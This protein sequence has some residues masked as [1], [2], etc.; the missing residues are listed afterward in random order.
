MT[1]RQPGASSTQT[2][3]SCSAQLPGPPRAAWSCLRRCLLKPGRRARADHPV[4]EFARHRVDRAGGSQCREILDCGTQ[5]PQRE[6]GSVRGHRRQNSMQADGEPGRRPQS[7]GRPPRAGYHRVGV[8]PRPRVVEPAAEP[9]L[10]H[11][12]EYCCAADRFRHRPTPPQARSPGRRSFPRR[13][14]AAQ[15]HRPRSTQ[16]P[17]HEGC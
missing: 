10:R 8:L 2:I 15:E 4:D 17:A 12:I 13:G 16:S 9:Q 14:G 7:T 3:R 6:A 11:R 1:R 5:H